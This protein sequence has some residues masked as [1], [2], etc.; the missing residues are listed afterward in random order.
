MLRQR[1]VDVIKKKFLPKK[2][3]AAKIDNATVRSYF[4][5]WSYF[6]SKLSSQDKTSG[7]DT[8]HALC[9]I[10]QKVGHFKNADTGDP[11]AVHSEKVALI[12][13][14]FMCLSG[15]PWAIQ[16]RHVLS[17]VKRTKQKKC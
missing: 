17:Y 11:L 9:K 14:S 6:S 1:H 3:S 8:F 2:F 13:F 4:G 10:V 5:F 15:R 7:A 16:T 12:A